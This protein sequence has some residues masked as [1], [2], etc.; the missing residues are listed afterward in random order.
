VGVVAIRDPTDRMAQDLH[1]RLGD[2]L[3]VV[4]RASLPQVLQLPG[5]L[6]AGLDVQPR[7]KPARPQ[8]ARNRAFGRFPWVSFS[9]LC[10]AIRFVIRT[11]R[12]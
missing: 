12:S 9:P 8:S 4:R 6:L 5:L 7:L 10:Y 3:V 1:R 11:D 2:V